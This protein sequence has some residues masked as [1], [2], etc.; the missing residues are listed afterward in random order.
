MSEAAAPL[1]SA[2]NATP[3]RAFPQ[4]KKREIFGW[5]CFDFANSA[6]TTI[7][8][9]VI[10]ARYFVGVVAEGAE[11]APAWWGWAL[12]ASQV[13]VILLSPLIGAVA[14]AKAAKKRFLMTTALVCSVATMALYFVGRGEIWLALGLVA[15]ANVAFSLS[16]NLCSAFL[17]E[18]STPETAGQISGFGWSFGYV[19]GLISLVIALGIFKSGEGREPWIFVMTGAFFLLASL[20]TLLLLR[21]RAVATP[22]RAGESYLKAGWQA[23]VALLKEL[24]QH[25]TLFIFFVAM[26]FFIAGLMAV[27]SFSAI[28]A[29]QVL[30]MSM[31][32]TVTL[33]MVLQLA[34]VVGAVVFGLVQDRVGSKVALIASLILWVIVSVCVAGCQTKEQFMAIGVIAGLALGSLQS[35]G[36]AVVSMLTPPSRSGE[37]F[38]CW[39]FFGKLAA[40][41][42]PLVFGELAA[43]FGYRTAILAN[44]GFFLIGLVIV[45]T[46]DL[47]KRALVAEAEK[48]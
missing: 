20:P 48:K 1:S 23:N 5:C 44:G 11:R 38:G 13:V 32:E 18:I 21:E 34:G 6:F 47:R 12:A 3:A 28:F 9:T 46:L 36:R 30:K 33:F 26:V 19:G 10:Y 35:A 8:I 2:S 29:D 17:P 37:F 45:A 4:V 22:L 7:I 25:R 14:D 41:I 31:G 16:E 42:G 39:G 15:V 43:G 40:L 27:V 24:P